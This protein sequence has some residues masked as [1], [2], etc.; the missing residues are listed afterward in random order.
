MIPE[1][2]VSENHQHVKEHV[3]DKALDICSNCVRDL[4]EEMMED[5]ELPCEQLGR[6]RGHDYEE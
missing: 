6:V 1:G 3:C 4:V 5:P 2:R